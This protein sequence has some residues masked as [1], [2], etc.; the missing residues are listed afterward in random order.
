MS[1][2]VLNVTVLPIS[3][4]K[5]FNNY[6]ITLIFIICITVASTEF[7]THWTFH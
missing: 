2:N 1:H 3:T 4:V 6:K 7:R 5:L